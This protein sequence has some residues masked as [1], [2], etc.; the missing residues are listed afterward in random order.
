MKNEIVKKSI[1]MF[2]S[3]G[4]TETSI[5]DIVDALGVTKG[6]FYHYFTSKEQLLM[7]IHFQYIDTLLRKQQL[8]L[9]DASKDYKTKLHDNIH[10][11][12]TGIATHGQEGRVFF[13]EIRNL[14]PD[15]LIIIKKKR[16]E[17]RFN[18]QKV[19]ELGIK[20]GE[21]RRDLRSDM[22]AFGILGMCNW[23]YYWYNPEGVVPEYELIH[24]YLEVA[25]NGIL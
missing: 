13:R 18:F 23:S 20:N 7:D 17:F 5:Q 15:N 12:I 11:L 6:T 19:I 3:K 2:E 9:E 25:I 24:T 8:I 10:L 4:F 1:E 22:V 14:N 16:D 21:F